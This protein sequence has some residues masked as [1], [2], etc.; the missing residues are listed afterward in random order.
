MKL[1]E[2]TRSF[3][4]K[5]N[6]GNYQTADFFCSQ[7]SEVPEDQAEEK[8][9]ALY[10]FCKEE[11]MKSVDEYR[12]EQLTKIKIPKKKI[13]KR[14]QKSQAEQEFSEKIEKELQGLKFK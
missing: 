12:G 7:K 9:E 6:L 5:L 4:Y 3:S 13:P 14:D 2:I 8:S 10:Q 11:V 1:T